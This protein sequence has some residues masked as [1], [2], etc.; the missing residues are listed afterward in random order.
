LG[1]FLVEDRKIGASDCHR[2]DITAELL[3]FLDHLLHEGG[4]FRTD[5][6]EKSQKLLSSDPGEI[7]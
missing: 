6:V 5:Q 2:I 1:W 7:S 3:A 4:Q